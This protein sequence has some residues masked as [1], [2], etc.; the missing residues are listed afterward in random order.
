MLAFTSEWKFISI[1]KE[2]ILFKLSFKII[3]DGLTSAFVFSKIKLVISFGFIEP[4]K[5]PFSLL[6]L[7]IEKVLL[8][9]NLAISLNLFLISVFFLFNSSFFLFTKSWFSLLNLK[10][11]PCFKRKFL[12]YPFLTFTLS[13]IFPR[14]KMFSNSIISFLYKT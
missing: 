14:F 9:I 10:A 4:Y 3:W 12:P 2:P 11:F 7:T 5:S 8:L 13:P 1:L 6:S